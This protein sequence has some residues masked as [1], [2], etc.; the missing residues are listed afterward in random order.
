MISIVRRKFRQDA[1]FIA[2]QDDSLHS[3]LRSGPQSVVADSV[4]ALRN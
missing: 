4:S 1:I 2:D 3:I